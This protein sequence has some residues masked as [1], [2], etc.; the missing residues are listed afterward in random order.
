MPTSRSTRNGRMLVMALLI[1]A[2]AMAIFA[3]ANR[4]K[5]VPVTQPATAPVSA[6]E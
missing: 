3:R 5:I 4:V 1:G 6:E 2:I